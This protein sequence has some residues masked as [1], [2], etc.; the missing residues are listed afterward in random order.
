V[1]FGDFQLLSQNFGQ[2]TSLGAAAAA[3]FNTINSFSVAD[4]IPSAIF[5]AGDPDN[6]ILD[7]VVTGIESL[8]FSEIPLDLA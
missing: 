1:N 5:P 8:S 2:T 3:R 6:A 7:G 4:T